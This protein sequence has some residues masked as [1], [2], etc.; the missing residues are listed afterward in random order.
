VARLPEY[1]PQAMGLYGNYN[2]LRQ[3]PASLR[4]LFDFLVDWFSHDPRW[5]ALAQPS[6]MCRC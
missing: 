1:R 2:L 4:M 5:R 6:A 3:F